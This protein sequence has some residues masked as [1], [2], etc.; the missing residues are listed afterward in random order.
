MRSAFLATAAILCVSAQVPVIPAP[1]YSERRAKLRKNIDGVLVLFG[2]K[3]GADE[4]YRVTQHSSF[5][6][7]TGFEEPGAILLLSAD[8]EVLFVPPRDAR[9]E[10]YN[11]KRVAAADPDASQRTGFREVAGVEK[12]ESRLSKALESAGPI[13]ALLNDPDTPK[14]RSLAPFREVKEASP[15]LAKSRM[16]KSGAELAA[17][18]YA[19]EVSMRAHLASWKK[20][21]PGSHEYHGVAAF[22]QVLTDAGCER[23]AYEPIFGSG[24]NSVVLHYNA[25]R[26]KMDQGE[27]IVIDAAASCGGYASDITRSLP[28]GG[29]F[30]DRQ[31]QVYEVVLGSLKAATAALRP[32]VTLA[33]MT[34]LAKKYMDDH[35]GL[36]KYFVHGIG[37]HV[38]LDVHDLSTTEPLQS[39]A[40]VTLEPGIYIPEENLGIRI[41]DILVVTKEGAQVLS[42]GLPKEAAEIEK[43]MAR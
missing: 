23:H 38:G 32:G 25:N 28:I 43:A 41:E 22:T 10:R 42:G 14:L 4:V 26:R 6:Y 11:G 37:H 5:N 39:G 9:K 8:S 36:G 16:I 30:N 13:Y 24:P 27:I 2:W 40:V 15:L 31:K 1:E 12:F 35:G 33:E 7:L 21:Q 20:L 29:K 18:R 34:A 17:I 19:T 3:E